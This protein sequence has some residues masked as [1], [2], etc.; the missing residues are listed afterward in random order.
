[1]PH[2]LTLVMRQA[3]QSAP[4]DQVPAL[5]RLARVVATADQAE[6][7]RLLDRGVALLA[8]L[9]EREQQAITPQALC[10]AA[11]VSPARAFAL[12]AGASIAEE[13][14]KFLFDMANHGHLAAAVEF[15]VNWSEDGEFPH[16]GAAHVVHAVKGEHEKLQV[17]RSALRV[18]RRPYGRTWQAVRSL[19]HFLRFQ[20]RRLPEREARE[21]IGQVVDMIR[22]K[23]DE[24]AGE[25]VGGP[26][27][28]V[29]FSSRKS[30]LLFELL[31]PLRNLE[32]DLA[33][34]LIR[35]DS[36]LARAA[37]LYPRGHDTAVDRPA[38]PP[39]A[40]A[41]EQW[42]KDW[43]GFTLGHQF[44]RIE[45]E[46]KA[47]FRSSF[48]HAARSY[49]RDTPP[50]RTNPFPKECWPS[51]ED[52]RT[53]LYAAGRYEGEG[54]VRLLDRIPD[55]VLRLFAEIEF[56]AGLAGLPQIGGITRE[57]LHG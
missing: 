55:G 28:S 15:L 54:S 33:D 1:M 2:E 52:V 3:E 36:E 32:P 12:R 13:T 21:E 30:A 27:G 10:L 23:P 16:Q 51:T 49:M 19:V 42:K 57:Q 40:A 50:G 37:L 46:R 24:P 35:E 53:I 18:A 9:P 56:A 29:M 31:G 39:S 38:Q 20:W 8:A 48:E 22:I 43:T 25:R 14:D 4:D 44:F 26:R 34:A 47:D 5:L 6:A 7:A 45:D 11:S 17:V 41:L